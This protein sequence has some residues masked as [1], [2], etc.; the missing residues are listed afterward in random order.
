MCGQIISFAT[1]IVGGEFEILHVEGDRYLFRQIQYFDV[2]NGNPQAKDFQINASIFRK[3][4]NVFVRSVSLNYKTESFVPYT[5]PICTNDQLVTNR[6]IYEAEVFLNPNLFSAPQGY[7]LVWERCCRNSIISNIVKPD[8]TGQTFYLEFP[9]VRK[10]GVAFRNSS[11]Q[12]FPPLSDY[13]CVN[14]L[15]YVDFRG[16]DPDG[17]SLSYRLVTPLNSSEFLPLPTPTPSPHPEVLW[18]FGSNSI[19]QIPGNPTLKINTSGFLTVTPSREGLFVF[20]VKCEEFRRGLKIGEVVRDFQLFVIDC[21]DPG[22]P[23]VI[24]V[25]APKTDFFIS[26]VDTIKLKV[27]DDKCFDFKIKDKDGSETIS[28]IAEAVNF[29][30]N[31]NTILSADIGYL[32]LPDDT[33]GIQVCLPDCPYLQNEPFIIDIIA[34]DLTCPQPL[35][36]TMRLIVLVEPP[37]NQAPKFIEPVQDVITATYIEGSMINISFKVE[38]KDLDSLLLYVE[39]EGF[40]LAEYGIDIDTLIFES[41]KIDFNFSWDTDCQVYPFGIKNNFQ[42]KFYAEDVDQCGLDNRDS[43]TLNITIDLPDNNSPVV[44]INNAGE[45]KELTVRIDDDL[46]FD[47]RAFDGD[48]T[49]LLSLEAIGVGFDLEEAGMSF[50]NITGSSNVKNQLQWEIDCDDVKLYLKDQYEIYF[51]AE[52]ADKCKI[53]NA[54]TVKLTLNILPPLNDAPEL[55][56]N[57]EVLRDTLFVN[58]GNLLDL[59]ITGV[60]P[61]GDSIS[62]NLLNEGILKDLGINFQQQSGI[63]SVFSPFRWET[64][65][66]H[67]AENYENATYN[68]KLM[69]QDYKCLVPLA[70]TLDMVI[71]IRDEKINYDIML[72]N[73]YTPNSDNVNESYFVPNLPKKNCERQF[74]RIVIFNRLGREVF[75]SN[76]REFNWYGDDHP[77]GVYFYLISY[78]DFTI[79]GT[80]SLLR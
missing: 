58:A 23:P 15:Y 11:P 3:K 40:E 28:I 74:E 52:D 29:E 12:L 35:M 37:P 60:D 38:D 65:C 51:I 18:A 34:R 4:D 43:I 16:F 17:D 80:I 7:Y 2:V 73:V 44:L 50:E 9:P 26:Q 24:E 67:L 10:N 63:E 22:S 62:L 69:L 5:N 56:V 59:D 64:D 14:R 77:A 54:D 79:K 70:D 41:G 19:N 33:L 55:F 31:L 1:H 42:L 66:S 25:K 48:P 75:S 6:I 30:A 68:F 36:D 53:Q 72:P 21:P 78:S 47:I 8:E 49:D 46:S 61:N 32:N 71:V 45:D 76:E 57:G 27:E 39:G 13:A 20:S